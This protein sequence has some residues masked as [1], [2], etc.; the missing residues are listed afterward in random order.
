VLSCQNCGEENPERARFCLA[1]G[2][3]LAERRPDAEE[4]K[5]VSVLF[6]DLVGFTV[7]SDRADP[8]DVRATLRPYHARVRREIDRYGGTVEKFVGDAVMAVFGA[9]VAHE[10]DAERAVR[11]ALRI[12]DAIEEL[13]EEEGLAL[14]V[15]GA[16][17][18]GEA[19]VSLGARPGEGE[20]IATGD[21]VNTAAR[22]QNEAPI[23]GLVVG[24]GTYRATRGT[25]D[26]EELTPVA[27]KGKTGAVPLWRALGAR[28]RFGVDA[29]AAPRTPFV[30][31]EH[32]L[33]LL[34]DTFERMLR[35]TEIQLVTVT[36]EPGVGKT[37]LLAELRAWVDDRPELVSWRQGRCLPYGEGISFWALGE[38]VKAQAGILES[39]SSAEAEAKLHVAVEALTDREWLHARLTPLV[40]LGGSGAVE[41]EE[42][43]T[44]WQRFLEGVAAQGPLV[45]LFEDLHWADPALLEFV[46]RLVDWSSGLPI[47]VLCTG[48]PELFERNPGWGGG[49][50]NTATVSLSPLSPDETARLVSALLETAVLPAE[51]QA[52]LLDRAGGN[53]LYAEEYVRLFLELGSAE[54]LPLPDTVQ[55]LIAARLDTLPPAGKAMLQDAAVVGK[56]FWA[57]ALEAMGGHAS[58]QV[59]ADLRGLVRK[60]LVR[61]ARSSSVER[62]AEYAFWHGLIRDVAYGQ[63]PRAQRAAKHLAAADWIEA[64][65]EERVAD[66]AEL[67]AYHLTEALSLT[68]AAG[69]EVDP[70]LEPRAARYLVLAGDRSFEL[71]LSAAETFYRRALELLP[72][73]SQEHGLALMKAGEAA[74]FGARFEKARADFEQAA[75]ELE[76]AGALES[77]GVAL[78][79]LGNTHYQLGQAERMQ[80][81]LAHALEILEPL[82]PSPVL[83]DIYGRMA[84]LSSMKGL[85]PERSIEWAE[86]AIALGEEL[87]ARSE[88]VRPLQWRGLMRCE[89]GDLAGIEDL[90]RALAE[91]IALRVTVTP[92]HVNLADQLWRQRGPA[93]AL[94]V[95]EAAIA[96]RLS[97]GGTPPTWVQ[98]E[99]CWMLFDLGEWDELLQVA[100]EVRRSEAQHGAAQPGAMA[101]TYASLVHVWRDAAGDGSPPVGDVLAQARPIDDPQVLAPALVVAALA[102]AGRGETARALTLLREYY[103]V[104]C[105]RPYH[106]T[107]NLTDA[108]RIACAA[109]DLALAERLLDNVVT[110]AERDRLSDLT[111][112]A[113]IDESRSGHAAAASGYAEAARGWEGFG[114]TLE[115]ALALLG[116][117]RCLA[118]LGR[119]AEATA[120]VAEADALLGRLRVSRR[121]VQLAARAAK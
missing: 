22:L 12:L 28:S 73:G 84:A 66:H 64:M 37:R 18:T 4:R 16:V 33:R 17:D 9:P 90:E 39:D 38:I 72:A 14:A 103:D 86:K 47:L 50:R 11:A 121:P 82:P 53:P 48:R 25:I 20:G 3:A 116:Q 36:G 119:D 94:E 67:L 56:V 74:Q 71:D 52:A 110:A 109:G 29:E 78:G 21:V 13:N 76:T 69:D 49:K 30:G 1:C 104:T 81:V 97:H 75:R 100:E 117:A 112:R 42:S 63:I 101:Q 114:C 7:R 15:R 44:A 27:V 91:A 98:A 105:N 59:R 34:R 23:G 58:D 54:E 68:R 102:E 31:R 40:G 61:P 65:A 32:E 96:D 115:L 113:A 111:A 106:R 85:R 8:E 41:R 62:E 120:P 108:V 19:V 51:T 5:V 43:F 93:A 10:D 26:Y 77:A 107:Q 55:G 2:A 60:E 92:A 80:E 79:L 46:E 118:A 24:E 88:L 35:E 87:G 99:S 89:L 95:Q 6:V 70:E 57:G 45:L 83:V